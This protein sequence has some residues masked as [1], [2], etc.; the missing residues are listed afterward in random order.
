M[1]IA[2]ATEQ[3]IVGALRAGVQRALRANP[4]CSLI[5]GGGVAANG[6]LRTALASVATEE[7]RTLVV[8]PLKW[9]TDNAA[10]IGAAGD[11]LLRDGRGVYQEPGAGLEVHAQ[12]RI[13]TEVPA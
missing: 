13:G 8:P 6:P 4:D 10:M 11:A 3:A 9:C 2:A 5:V 7:Q 12:W 1:T